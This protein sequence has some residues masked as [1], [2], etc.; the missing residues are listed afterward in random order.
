[1]RFW[2]SALIPDTRTR[3]DALTSISHDHQ[4]SSGVLEGLAMPRIA[5]KVNVQTL[6]DRM[7]KRIVKK[8]RPEKIILF[9]SHARGDAGPDSDVDLLVVMSL[10]GPKHD[11]AVEILGA[12]DDI[13]VP[14]DVIVTSP[15][16]FAWRKV[17]LGH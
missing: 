9:G 10:E 2:A 3:P 12:L 5:K 17:R 11:K 16:D 4:F 7:V 8:F 15:E 1:M 13:V 6:I 14:T